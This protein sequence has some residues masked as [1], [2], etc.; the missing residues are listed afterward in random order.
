MIKAKLTLVIKLDITDMKGWLRNRA[1]YN[2]SGDSS[3]PSPVQNGCN[4]G[5]VTLLAVVDS[6]E[7][8]ICSFLN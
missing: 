5:D 7:H 2:N 3:S 1:H 4:I 6:L 8:A